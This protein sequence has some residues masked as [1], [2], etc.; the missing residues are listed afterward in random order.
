MDP[1]K[2]VVYIILGYFC[3]GLIAAIIYAIIL[4]IKNEK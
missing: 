1:N 2:I 3:A 4:A